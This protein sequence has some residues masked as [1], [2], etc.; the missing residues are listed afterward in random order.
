MPLSPIFQLFR[1]GQF[2]WWRKREYLEKTTDLSQVTGKH[3]KQFPKNKTATH[4]VKTVPKKQKLPPT[5]SKQFQKRGL[6]WSG[7]SSPF[8]RTVL[9]VWVA[10]L[11]FHC[12]ILFHHILSSYCKQVHK[13]KS[14]CIT[15]CFFYIRFFRSE[16][17]IKLINV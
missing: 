8:F 15:V 6:S 3:S 12:I 16:I 11:V 7:G 10:V 2:Y 13:S 9:T 1:G 5:L 14:T 17:N 4:T